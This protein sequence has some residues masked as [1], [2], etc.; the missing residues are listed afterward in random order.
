MNFPDLGVRGANISSA[1]GSG[2]DLF[3]GGIAREVL[4]KLRKD[5]L[6][7]PRAPMMRTLQSCQYKSRKKVMS[8]LT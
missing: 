5:V 8:K 4:R 1:N 6:P 3:L 7:A 2:F